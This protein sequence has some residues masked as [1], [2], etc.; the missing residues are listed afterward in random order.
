M[1]ANY[2]RKTLHSTA[3]KVLLTK[4]V[5]ANRIELLKY[6]NSGDAMPGGRK[7]VVGYDLTGLMVGAEGTLGIITELTVKLIPHPREVRAAAALFPD[8][9]ASVAAVA[10]VMAGGVSP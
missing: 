1:T 2:I 5:C 4:A 3:A 9:R 7:G 6:A 10:A 8:A